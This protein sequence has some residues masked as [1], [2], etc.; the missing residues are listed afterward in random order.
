VSNQVPDH[1]VKKRMAD[2]ER[3]RKSSIKKID[4]FFS[5]EKVCALL[6][7]AFIILMILIV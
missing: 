3:N 2:D 5:N 1:I 6:T 7:V 4:G